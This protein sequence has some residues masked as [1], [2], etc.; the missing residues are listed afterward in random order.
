MQSITSQSRCPVA[1]R[2]LS[3][4]PKEILRTRKTV[5][6]WALEVTESP[7]RKLKKKT[8]DCLNE[9]VPAEALIIKKYRKYS[10]LACLHILSFRTFSIFLLLSPYIYRELV[11]FVKNEGLGNGLSRIKNRI[12][13]DFA[14]NT[15]ITYI[16][17]DFR[18]NHC[19]VVYEKGCLRPVAFT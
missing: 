1:R 17:L 6:H 11:T 18:K 4:S 13:R 16:I 7:P 9:I 10:N 19:I 8:T 14:K 5:L 15:K 3:E 2:P 12:F